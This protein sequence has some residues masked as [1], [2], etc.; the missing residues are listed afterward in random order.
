[1]R[2]R[3]GT[4]RNRSDGAIHRAVG[5]V[6]ILNVVLDDS[7]VVVRDVVV[8]R[9]RGDVGDVRVGHVD[10]LEVFA[11]HVIGGNIWFTPAKGEPSHAA[12]STE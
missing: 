5:V 7:R 11:G 12:A 10:L 2:T 8:V 4:G 1:M 6:N 9:D 3:H